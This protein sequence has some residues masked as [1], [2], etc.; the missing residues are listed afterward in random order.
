MDRLQKDLDEVLKHLKDKEWKM[1]KIKF[2][3]W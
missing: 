1:K 3:S 2:E